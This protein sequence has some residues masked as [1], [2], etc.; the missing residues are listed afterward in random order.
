[1]NVDMPQMHLVK[2]LVQSAKSRQFHMHQEL[3]DY[4]ISKEKKY[5]LNYVNLGWELLQ[6]IYSK[7]YNIYSIRKRKKAK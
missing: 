4:I 3:H 7:S 5:I 2:T 1:M 6:K